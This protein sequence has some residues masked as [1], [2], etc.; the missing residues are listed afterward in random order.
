MDGRGL[1]HISLVQGLNDNYVR[2]RVFKDAEIWKTM[3]DA[4]DSTAQIARTAQK[5]K[6]YN[7]PRMRNPLTSMLYLTILIVVKEVLLVGTRALIGVT[8]PAAGMTARTVHIKLQ[9]T[10][11][12][13]KTPVENQ[14]VINAQV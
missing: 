1:N 8:M 3:A 2:Q 14:Y 10:I 9:G 5:T 4:F 12:P 7:E 11:H 13:G 6:V